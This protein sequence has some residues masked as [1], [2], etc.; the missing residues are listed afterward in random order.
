MYQ[1]VKTASNGG[2][3]L[4]WITV[5]LFLSPHILMFCI[6]Q[7]LVKVHTSLLKEVQD[8]VL[9]HNASNLF[10]IFINYKERCLIYP[11][12]YSKKETLLPLL[13]CVCFPCDRLVLYGKYCSQVEPA[14]ACLD[15]ICKN[16]EDVRQM[17][18]VRHCQTIFIKHLGSWVAFSM[19]TGQFFSIK[20]THIS[21]EEFE[22]LRITII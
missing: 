4:A 5:L 8:S 17:L 19:N 9:M 21:C 18:E 6:V 13:T 1:W 15:D 16:R 2:H 3:I 10:Q 7:D 12:S 14:I 22:M 11:F 20:G